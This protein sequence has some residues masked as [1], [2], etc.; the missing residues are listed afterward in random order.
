MRFD[1]K[2]A[3]LRIIDNTPTT[4]NELE[5]HLAEGTLT[6]TER[7]PRVYRKNRGKLNDVQNGDEEP[8]EVRFDAAWE[9]LKASSGDPPTVREALLGIGEAADWV[10]TDTNLCAPYSVTLELEHTP[11]CESEDI[12]SVKFELFRVEEISG[13]PNDSM[14]SFTGKC[15]KVAPTVTRTAQA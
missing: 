9:A 2:N 8:M 5:I 14:I 4:P 6:Y 10:S 3:I 7:Y 1:F 11:V 12:E 15:N 13:N